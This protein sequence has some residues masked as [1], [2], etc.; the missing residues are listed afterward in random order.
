MSSC[1]GIGYSKI[2]ELNMGILSHYIL[3]VIEKNEL[4]KVLVYTSLP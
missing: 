2:I 1:I 3:N 4:Y